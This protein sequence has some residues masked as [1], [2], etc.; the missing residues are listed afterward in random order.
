MDGLTML[1]AVALIFIPIG[2]WQFKQDKKGGR[3][4]K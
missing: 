2:I 4:W 1:V 3:R